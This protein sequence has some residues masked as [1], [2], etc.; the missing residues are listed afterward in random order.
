[1][2][3][4][5]FE[6][7]I[8][9]GDLKIVTDVLNRDKQ[10]T[11]IQLD[12][13]KYPI[14][15]AA[16][17]GQVDIMKK[18]LNAGANSYSKDSYKKTALILAAEKGHVSIVRLLVSQIVQSTV[19]KN[20]VAEALLGDL[21]SLSPSVVDV[22]VKG[23]L[24]KVPGVLN[25]ILWLDRKY[26]GTESKILCRLYRNKCMKLTDAT[27][28]FHILV[29]LI[30][31][32]CQVDRL[33][34][35]K[36]ITRTVN[37]LIK[38][39]FNINSKFMY[40]IDEFKGPTSPMDITLR[41]IH[42]ENPPSNIKKTT[43]LRIQHLYHIFSS[44][45][46]KLSNGFLKPK[47]A[48]QKKKQRNK[49]TNWTGY[50]YQNIQNLRR[51]QPRPI[52]GA[53]YPYIKNRIEASE[54]RKA[55]KAVDINR[56]MAQVFRN[57]AIRA[58]VL[59]LKYSHTKFLYRGV[60]DWQ[61]EQ[62]LK[63]GKL[64]ISGYIAFSRSR[65]RAFEFAEKGNVGVLMRLRVEDVPKGTPWIWFD[66]SNN[67]DK[68]SS[69]SNSNSSN[70][71]K[72]NSNNRANKVNRQLE[73]SKHSE[74]KN[75]YHSSLSSEEEVLLPPGEL[76]LTNYHD[77]IYTESV[78]SKHSISIYEIVYKPNRNSISL[79]GKRLYR[80]QKQST[81]QA[82]EQNENAIL[83]WYMTMFDIQD[84]KRKRT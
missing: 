56:H 49:I 84:K 58:P 81:A 60:H 65:S 15:V 48:T 70:N 59:P 18:L 6:R 64:D 31:D 73:Y 39:G 1:M 17:Y 11:D 82:S 35:T 23:G 51:R 79:E 12:G 53:V 2:V 46:A 63:S 27:Y 13:G 34:S 57:T 77:P 76:I 16:T 66:H 83:S 69:K 45:G 25:H 72:S 71:N 19:Q 7:A 33:D 50:S 67:S 5:N 54:Y 36:K 3:T 55:L 4:N 37:H 42:I 52:F 8:R 78:V 32:D 68:S 24:F 74:T 44:L 80:S 22:L 29:A 21:R 26:L 75:L 40:K 47:K 38:K 9:N 61:A 41:Y 10:M 43:L 62:L 14:H 20:K 28:P 30:E